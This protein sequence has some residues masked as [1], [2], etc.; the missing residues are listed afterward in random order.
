MN[1]SS[2]F[3]LVVT[4]FVAAF[5]SAARAD[6]SQQYTISVPGMTSVVMV[7]VPG[8]FRPAATPAEA[9]NRQALIDALQTNLLG[10]AVVSEVFIPDWTRPFALPV[11]Y[12]GTLPIAER[13]QGK[14]TRDYWRKFKEMFTLWISALN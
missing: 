5:S 4:T 10:K 8:A 6:D 11:L 1:Q 7:R 13:A 14:F 9:S 2:I 3:F 12:I